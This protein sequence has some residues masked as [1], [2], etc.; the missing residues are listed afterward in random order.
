MDLL[1]FSLF[2][3]GL[4]ASIAS[5]PGLWALGRQRRML[6]WLL[7]AGAVVVTIPVAIIADRMRT[8]ALLEE[9]FTPD[10]WP[11]SLALPF[12]FGLLYILAAS[13]VCVVF[14]LLAKRR[15]RQTK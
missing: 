5:I 15:D 9:G 11:V 12:V 2:I 4:P 1:V 3:Y 14:A 10:D 8:R 13:I 7:I 6:G